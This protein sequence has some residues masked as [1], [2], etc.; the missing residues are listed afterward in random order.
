MKPGV[1]ML[2]A[3]DFGFSPKKMLTRLCYID[4]DGERFLNANI[5]VKLLMT[6]LLKSMHQMWLKVSKNYQIG[7]KIYKDSL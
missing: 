3:S 6:E 2:P 7:L 1:A 5:N 4:F